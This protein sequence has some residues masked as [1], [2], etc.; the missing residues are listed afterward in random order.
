MPIRFGLC[1]DVQ[2]AAR[3]SAFNSDGNFLR[4]D[5]STGMLSEA[6]DYWRAYPH[7][8]SFVLH[9]GDVVDG[10]DD[11][12]ATRSDLDA[13][14]AQFD[15]LDVDVCHALGNHCVKFLSRPAVMEALK[16]P[17]GPEGL[18]YY[19][20]R[21]GAGWRL[22]VLDTTDL[23]T[24]GG[25]PEGSS[26]AAA[27]AA[28]MLSHSGEARMKRYNGG[29]GQKQMVWLA[30]ELAS[31]RQAECRV[32]VVSHHCLAP[33]ACRETHR[34]W[35]GDE[36]VDVLAASGVVSLCLAGHD[37]HGGFA[38]VRGIP[39]VTVEAILEAPVGSNAYG[40]CSL[41]DARAEICGAG[42]AITTRTIAL[43]HVPWQTRAADAK[44]SSSSKDLFLLGLGSPEPAP[45]SATLDVCPPAPLPPTSADPDADALAALE[46][47]AMRAEVAWLLEVES[48]QVLSSVR[49][50][51]QR[52]AGE[53]DFAA[54]P[55]TN[56]AAMR[57]G[58]EEDGLL[59]AT[60][61]G[62]TSLHALRLQVDAFPKWN[63]GAA[64]LGMLMGGQRASIPIPALLHVRNR[65]VQALAAV[66]AGH[67]TLVNARRTV[68]S[69]LTLV[70]DAVRTLSLAPALIAPSPVATS[71]TG[72]MQ[73]PVPPGMVLD[74]VVHGHSLIFSAYLL[75]KEGGVAD[76]RHVTL[77]TDELGERRDALT[78]AMHT[79]RGLLAKLDA[80]SDAV[81]GV[82][83]GPM[84][85]PPMTELPLSVT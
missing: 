6:I 49:E 58:R 48:E 82:P 59:L 27:G 52:V 15:R 18:A 80:V 45:E 30:A 77:E 37:H 55:T 85:M 84:A 31:A 7:E 50:T 72:L 79:M 41:H 10:R 56:L 21:L 40:V 36:V 29:V 13:V 8:L 68:S 26:E 33:G 83:D 42:T 65:V 17:S 34:A 19:V 28:Y 47:A 66:G 46:A 25:W 24:H 43:P 1:T 3:P 4:Y 38:V 71:I 69:A 20:R 5:E 78:H 16:F 64:Y 2:A 32:L 73:P 35:N 57:G 9:C 14:L 44:P 62:S 23:S 12:E 54:R 51:L 61:V 11:E 63:Q 76:T 53:I 70:A 74:V 67:R 81:Q 60:V 75:T 39:F 22:V